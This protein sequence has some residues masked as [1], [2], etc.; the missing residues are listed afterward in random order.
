MN[1]SHYF[2]FFQAEDGIRDVAVTGVQTCALPIS[3]AAN[4]LSSVTAERRG[5]IDMAIRSSMTFKSE[6]GWLG[7]T[8]CTAARIAPAK[9]AASPLVRAIRKV[10]GEVFLLKGERE[11]PLPGPL[12]PLSDAFPPPTPAGRPPP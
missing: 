4:T 6:T 5:P 1:E 3:I 10:A 12:P 8:S 9:D 7:S 2:F 11:K